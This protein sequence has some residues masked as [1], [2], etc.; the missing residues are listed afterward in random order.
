M[1]NSDRSG[2]GRAAAMVL[3]AVVFLA[4]IGASVGYVLGADEARARAAAQ[5]RASTGG[6]PTATGT[7]SNNNPTSGPTNNGNNNGGN[8]ATSSPTASPKVS[9]Y[10]TPQP[11]LDHTEQLAKAAGSNGSLTIVM[12]IKTNGSEVWVCKDVDGKLWYQGHVRSSNERNT[13]N[14]DPFVEGTNALFLS[15][16]APEGTGYVATNAN[17][18]GTTKYHVS[19]RRLVIEFSNGN[20][21]NQPVIEAW[22]A[23]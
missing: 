13:G 17:D 22:V 16:V 20:Q 12:Y 8:T 2:P 11:C 19:T 5:N 9:T 23:G 15:T 10:T 6:N 21:E 1:S 3:L 4:V 7:A 14:R 18:K